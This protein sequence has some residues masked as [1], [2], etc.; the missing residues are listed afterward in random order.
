MLNFTATKLSERYIEHA[1]GKRYNLMFDA[2]LTPL[3]WFTGMFTAA[4]DFLRSHGLT[5]TEETTL[6]VISVGNLT[7]G[8]T[9]K[10]P[11]T[12]MLAE[13]AKSKGIKA[14][15]VTRGYKGKSRDVTV[16]TGGEGELGV[17]GDEALMIS[18]KLP[19]VPVAVSKKRTDGINAL[20]EMGIE[21]VIA[22]DAFQHK[23]MHR[24]C[25]IVLIDALCP[26]GNGRLI[27]SGIM[28]ESVTALKRADITVITKSSMAAPETL[29]EIYGTVSKYSNPENIFMSDII[30]DGWTMNEPP[31]GS[32]VFAFSATGS[33]ETFT[34]SLSERGCK[35]AGQKAFTDHHRYTHD[36]VRM[37]NALALSTNAKYMVCTEKDLANM[38]E[39][40]PK[41][42]SLPLAVP[43]VKVKIK[44]FDNFSAKLA[45]V[46]RPEIVIAS[47]GYGEDAIGAVLAVKMKEAY[48]DSNVSAFPLV[49]RGEAYRR[50]GV[51]VMS[52]KSVTPSGG[53]LKYSLRDLWADLRAGLLR[54]VREQ[55]RDWR[56]FS[57]RIL[58][59]LCVG[60]VYL[61]LNTLW[62]SGKRPLFTATAKTVY[63]SGHWRTERA[64][65]RAFTLRTWTRD[66][67]TAQQIGGNASYSGSPVMDLLGD[68]EFTS[69]NVILLLPGSRKSASGDVKILLRAVE[70]MSREGYGEY[71]MVLAPT[72]DFESFFASCGEEGWTHSGDSLTKNGITILLTGEEISVAADGAL[73]L[74]GMGGTAN[75]LCAGLGI[76]VIAPDNKGKR[77]QKKLLGNAEIL[78]HGSAEAIAECALRVLGDEGLYTFMSETGKM[79]MGNAGACD[80]V[81]RY[82]ADVLGWKIRERVYRGLGSRD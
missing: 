20:R 49:G 59:P 81:V 61:L 53:V 13:Y 78:T 64:L 24:D 39:I 8:G 76:P 79:R 70:I 73:I 67:P 27:P 45:Q 57:R 69:G 65:I 10:T 18:R 68:S 29:R 14:G 12:I 37:L 51:E 6:P 31:E 16:I 4:A 62:G 1:K 15:I 34:R 11:F 38:P 7:Y 22:D 75:Q 56:K 25:D 41:E 32:E 43:K 23:S 28:R 50:A 2:V 48:P 47:N 9:N 36:D 55:L 63:I 66:E 3:S 21:L 52:A 71:R 42:F 72:L 35:V 77:V 19:D 5:E 54:Q 33:P 30:S 17:T 26:F 60:D 46:M 40:S 82:T 80:D 58:T 44:E 74:L